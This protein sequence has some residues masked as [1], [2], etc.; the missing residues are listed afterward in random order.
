MLR[1]IDDIHSI[2][3]GMNNLWDLL[4]TEECLISFYYVELE[5]IGL[6]DDLYIKMNARG[7][8]LTPFE[9]FKASLQKSILDNKWEENKDHSDRFLFKIDTCWTDFFWTNFRRQNSI[10]DAFMRFI[11]VIAM[12]RSSLERDSMKSE[13][14]FHLIQDIHENPRSIKAPFFSE[15][16]FRYLYNCLDKYHSISSSDDI[17]LTL[18]F[19]L[20]RHQPKKSIL[21]EIVYEEGAYS[22]SDSSRVSYSLKVLF[23]AQTEYLLRSKS[24]NKDL[25][26]DWMRVIRNIVSRGDIDKEGKRPDVIRSP[27]TFDGAIYLVNELAKGCDNIYRYLSDKIE[28]GSTFSK[29]QIDEE[30]RKARILTQRPKL[31]QLI[32][33]TEDNELLRGRI[34]FV[35]YCIDYDNNVDNINS[36]LLEKVMRVFKN[37]FNCDAEISNVL[38]RAMLTIDVDGKYEFYNYWWSWWNCIDA[39]KRKLFDNYRELEFFIYSEQREYFKTLILKLVKQDFQSIIDDFIPPGSMPNWKK[40]LIKDPS[41]LDEKGK[42]NFIAIPD[43]EECCYLLKSK[44]PRDTEGCFRVE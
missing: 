16:S 28:L 24:F 15:E 14:R 26:S 10:D 9:N 35:F 41:L 23:Y 19:P 38:R 37:N 7:K 30:K 29:N 2:F 39:T 8:L 6:T 34:D 44:R 25:F 43:D 11:S 18:E 17:D 42:S 3:Y 5:N 20:W 13:E 22:T 12:I 32:F 1:T 40:R 27:Q 21:S 4:T 31:K 33:D 36:E